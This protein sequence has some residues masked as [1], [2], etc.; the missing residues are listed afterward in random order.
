M[1]KEVCL[2]L[3]FLGL[4]VRN[5]GFKI[6]DVDGVWGL[7]YGGGSIQVMGSLVSMMESS[8]PCPQVSIQGTCGG[9]PRSLP[10]QIQMLQSIGAITIQVSR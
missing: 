7:L 9:F 5:L 10:K 3:G 1:P 2:A 6:H 8:Y 4:R